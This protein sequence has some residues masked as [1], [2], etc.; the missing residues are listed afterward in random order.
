MRYRA[1]QTCCF[2]EPNH[3]SAKEAL[4]DVYTRLGYGAENATWRGFYLTGAM[5]LRAGITPPELD[6]GGAIAA[7]LSV[8]QLFDTVAIRIN[9]PRAA[10]ASLCIQWHF[11]DL[12]FR[13]RTVRSNRALIRTPSTR[14]PCPVDLFATLT[15]TQLVACLRT[16]IPAP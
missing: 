12:D 10:A 14:T 9:G 16:A 2:A 13:I 5:E 1:A 8:E 3:L 11:T 6:L 4:A 7:A 15:K